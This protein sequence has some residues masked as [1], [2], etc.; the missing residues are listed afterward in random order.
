MAPA[1]PSSALGPPIL[2]VVKYSAEWVK[3]WTRLQTQHAEFCPEIATPVFDPFDDLQERVD[4]IKSF[5]RR[6]ELAWNEKMAEKIREENRKRKREEQEAAERRLQE[7]RERELREAAKKAKKVSGWFFSLSLSRSLIFFR[8]TKKR[9]AEEDDDEGP[10]G[11]RTRV[12]ADKEKL[13]NPAGKLFARKC[14]NCKARNLPCARHPDKSNAKSCWQCADRHLGGCEWDGDRDI[15]P[16]ELDG[17]L[18]EAFYDLRELLAG[19]S[20]YLV[21]SAQLHTVLLT[22]IR[23]LLKRQ[24][25]R[26]LESSGE[27]EEEEEKVSVVRGKIRRERDATTEESGDEA[28]GKGLKETEKSPVDGE[29]TLDNSAAS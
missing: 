5:E 4:I 7:R 1:R 15:A 14:L 20:E 8:E 13:R 17:A 18:V 10:P 27:E 9:A 6:V 25:E 2:P 12:P 21:K 22:E 24:E 3:K 11:K 29:A 16:E 26:E 19:Q 28:P 23:D